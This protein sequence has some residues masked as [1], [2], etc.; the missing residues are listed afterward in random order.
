MEGL[1]STLSEYQLSRSSSRGLR[2]REY[3]EKR[4]ER[5]DGRV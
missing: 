4:G 5:E 2:D 3:A 1:Y